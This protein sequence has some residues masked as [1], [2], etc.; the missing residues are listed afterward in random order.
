MALKINI[1]ILLS[2][3]FICHASFS[4]INQP[5]LP[6]NI[7]HPKNSIPSIILPPV[8]TEKL[9]EEDFIFEESG[10]KPF[11]FAQMIVTDISPETCGTWDT[12]DN[13]DKLWQLKISSPGAF[14]LSVVFDYFKVPQGAKL[15]IYNLKN[16]HILG[17]FTAQNNKKSKTLAIAPVKGDEIIIEYFEPRDVNFTG[18]L[19]ISSVGHDYKN[20]FNL[21]NDNE[22]NFGASGSCNVNINCPQGDNWQ[23]IKKSVCKITFN[24]FL[25]SGALLNNTRND[26]TPYLLTAKHCIDNAYDAEN[27]IFYFNYESP[28]CDN[29]NGDNTQALSGSTIKA[30]PLDKTLDFTL[31]E[32][33]EMP[34]PEYSPYY[35]GWSRDFA[36]PSTVT[37]IHH[38]SGDIKKITIANNGATTGN[39]GGVYTPNSHWWIEAWDI[40]TTEG[41]SSGSPLFD[42]NQRIIGDLTGGEASCNYN[43][44]DY[45]QQ[46]HRSWQDY[47]DPGQQLKTWLDPDSTGILFT[48]GYLPYDTIP[49]HL[50]A[51]VEDTLVNLKWN[52]IVNH[53]NLNT[54]YI[55]R[56]NVKIDSTTNISYTDSTTF[57]DSTYQYQVTAKFWPPD[58][59]ESAASNKAYIKRVDTLTPF[60]ETFEDSANVFNRWYEERTN[61]T[62]GWLIQTGGETEVL[63][64]A[65]EGDF[66]AYFQ[67]NNSESS[68]L[69]SPILNLS[70]GEHYLLNFY[71]HNPSNHDE[72]HQLDILYKETDSLNWKIIRSY[73]TDI[74]AWQKKQVPLPNLSSNY[75]IAFK[76]IGL[77][78]YGISIDSISIIEDFDH[79]DPQIIILSDTLCF[80]DSILIA[81]DLDKF[82][83][84]QWDFGKDAVPQQNTG[85]GPHWVKYNTIGVKEISL[86]VNNTYDKIQRISVYNIPEK[87]LFTVEENTLTSSS[88]INNQWYLN[89]VPIP[90]ATQ[91]TY[92]IETNGEYAVAVTNFA[93][94]TVFSDQQYLV[95]TSNTDH[96]KEIIQEQTEI[97]IY[98]NPNEGEFT[99]EIVSDKTQLKKYFYKVL[100]VTGSLIDEGALQSNLTQINLKNNHAGIYFLQIISAEQSKTY[101]ILI[102]R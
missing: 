41:G 44:N 35:A 14:S 28:N 20:I 25:C 24:G 52:E 71:L 18:E 6:H 3:I 34:P 36:D 73:N 82:Y 94:C 23:T 64:T 43:F 89:N 85:P 91:K 8:E 30:T 12:L 93:G 1:S 16:Q 2:F 58:N 86:M 37:S 81:T 76:A 69:V 11:R 10:L 87:P 79:I 51:W 15:F 75:R 4:Q 96:L 46:F 7:Y 31:L 61:D 39:F 92:T 83:D 50:K 5:G 32:L 33:S 65:F 38:P 68:R 47:P 100:D 22:K 88:A 57:I 27:A 19:H 29:I 45:Y 98:P 48:D 74:S 54:F 42:Q 101:K 60:Y 66:N 72:V 84:L 17:A 67:N 49:S 56:N 62:V 77:N 90:G 53:E 80:N 55:Y 26:G 95:V 9:L 40:G 99:I 13:G 102:K 59:N 63:D 97:K 70:N 21:F 78:G